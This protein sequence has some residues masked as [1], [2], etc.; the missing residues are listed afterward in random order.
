MVDQKIKE[1]CAED[2]VVFDDGN[3]LTWGDVARACG[4]E[5]ERFNIRTRVNRLVGRE[6]SSSSSARVQQFSNQ[7]EDEIEEEDDEGYK[8]LDEDDDACPMLDQDEY[9]ILQKYYVNT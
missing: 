8:S 5:E 6:A 4:V 1:E 9:C 2:D 3:D 7:R